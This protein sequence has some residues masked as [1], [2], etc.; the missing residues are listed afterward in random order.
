MKTFTKIYLSLAFSLVESIVFAQNVKMT[1]SPNGTVISNAGGTDIPLSSSILDIRSTN[2]GILLPRMTTTN[3]DAISSPQPGLLVYNTSTNQFNY[4]GGSSWQVASLGNQWGVNGSSLYHTGQVGIGTSTMTNANTSL[5]VKG[6]TTISG[7]LTT[8]G[9]KGILYNSGG[10]NQLKYYTF[11]FTQPMGLSG[12]HR[13]GE[14]TISISESYSSPPKVI[15]GDIVSSSCDVG[16]PYFLQLV[17]YG[18]TTNSCKARVIN[19]GNNDISCT[20]TWNIICIG[21]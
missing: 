19:T 16:E 14:I 18:C 20:T 4:Y 8:N 17:I 5:T 3:R 9:G 2:K 11:E 10:S 1:D 7:T 6:N 12:G 21:N 13:S 15:V